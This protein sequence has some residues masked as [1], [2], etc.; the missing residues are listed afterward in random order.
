MIDHREK[1]IEDNAEV[2]DFFASDLVIFNKLT[3]NDWVKLIKLCD[4]QFYI[5][6][7][8]I[9]T[10][11]EINTAIYFLVEG[12]VRIERRASDTTTVLA[13][14]SGSSVFGEMSFL[15][16]DIVS[17]DVVAEGTVELLRLG[18]DDLDILVESDKMFGLRFYH[19]LAITLSQRIRVTNTKVGN[20]KIGTI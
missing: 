6:K 2:E 14:L 20:S 15:D 13:R 9:L 5:S 4:R 11:G 18:K 17:A 8:K 16:G 7:S 3:I 10:I 19:S 1:G 12:H